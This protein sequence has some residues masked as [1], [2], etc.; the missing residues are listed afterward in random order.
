[1]IKKKY[2]FALT[3]IILG[4]FLLIGCGVSNKSLKILKEEQ[5]ENEVEYISNNFDLTEYQLK[6]YEDYADTENEQLLEDLMPMDIFKF[7]YHA[8]KINDYENLYSLYIKG[9]KYGTPARK[10]FLENIEKKDILKMSLLRSL[11]YNIKNFA[12]IKYDKNTSYIQV[13][14]KEDNKLTKNEKWNF[15]LIKNSYGI[16]KLEWL[17][18]NLIGNKI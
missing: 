2:L 6:I 17:P 5:I 16:W 11:E 15:K 3:L 7:F 10:D 8:F 4:S 18:F 9:E 12:Q 13:N 14:F 1:M